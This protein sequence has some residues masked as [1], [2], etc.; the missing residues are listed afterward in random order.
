MYYFEYCYIFG[1]SQ[2]TL[3]VIKER[4]GCLKGLIPFSS[5]WL[6]VL[7]YRCF[8]NSLWYKDKTPKSILRGCT[9]LLTDGYWFQARMSKGRFY[10]T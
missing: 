2:S 3:H 1:S 9:A 6:I 7:F 10:Y 8:Y 4:F 5:L